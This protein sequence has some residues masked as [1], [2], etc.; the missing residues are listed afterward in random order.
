MKNFVQVAENCE[1]TVTLLLQYKKHL[2]D[3]GDIYKNTYTNNHV[4]IERKMILTSQGY[5]SLWLNTFIA[6]SA[7]Y[8]V[9]LNINER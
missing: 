7:Y 1:E 8:I 6:T 4:Q 2:Q 9:D 5:N 3:F